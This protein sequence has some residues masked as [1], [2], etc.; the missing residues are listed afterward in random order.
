MERKE[1]KDMFER[2]VYQS[3]CEEEP[4]DDL[5]FCTRLAYALLEGPGKINQI[6]YAAKPQ[7]YYLR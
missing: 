6:M 5:H 7:Q 2:F 3:V 1:K 4:P